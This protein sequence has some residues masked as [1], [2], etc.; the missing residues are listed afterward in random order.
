[1]AK[2]LDNAIDEEL[3]NRSELFAKKLESEMHFKSNFTG[4]LLS[5]DWVDEIEQTCPY[6]DNV[7]RRPKLTLIREE[8]TVKIEKSKKITVAS[9]KDLARHTNY[10]SKVDKKTQDVQPSKILDIRNEETYNI[11]ENRFLYTLIDMMLKFILKKEELLN[12][13]EIKDNKLLEYAASSVTDKE[14]ISIEVKITSNELPKDQTDKKLQDDIEK[15]KYRIKRIK[16][17]ITSWQRSEM[18]KALEKAHIPLVQPPIKKTN[19]ILKNPN[20]QMAVKLWGFLQTYDTQDKD[21]KKDIMNNDGDESL[22]NF[23]DYSFLVDYYVLDAISKSKRE[24]KEKLSKYAILMITEQL[25]RTISLLTSNGVNVTEEDLLSLVAK[26]MKNKK[27]TRLV[28]VD[29][30]KKKF[31]SAID[32]YLERTQD[33]L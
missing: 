22:T 31:K 4:D 21:E 8:N 17:Y 3:K 28:G 18:M 23:L 13:F 11:Y 16:E 9:V 25:E 1:M 32:E 15:I 26:E 29:D 6:I 14:K 5:F 30:V 33:Y 19:I 7:V 27:G 20:F 24:Q 2:F 10:I 12:N